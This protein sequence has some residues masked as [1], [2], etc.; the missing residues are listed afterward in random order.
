MDKT[1]KIRNAFYIV[2]LCLFVASLVLIAFNKDFQIAACAFAGC[3][4]CVFE[5]SRALKP[6]PIICHK[7]TLK[8]YLQNLNALPLYK[9]IVR[10]LA[11][12]S[13]VMGIYTFVVELA[14][15]F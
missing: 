3:A 8:R 12:L 15:I 4:L 2:L 9:K 7:N 5:A 10:F 6:M 13:F 1:K 14:E 11:V